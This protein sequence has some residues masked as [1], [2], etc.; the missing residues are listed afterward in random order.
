MARSRIR[1]EEQGIIVISD[2]ENPC[3]I[4]CERLSKLYG[5]F[6]DN[7]CDIYDDCCT[8]YYKDCNK[9][10]YLVEKP[11]QLGP[12]NLKLVNKTSIIIK[13]KGSCC[14]PTEPKDCYCDSRCKD[15]DDCCSDYNIDCKKLAASKSKSSPSNTTKAQNITSKTHKSQNKTSENKNRD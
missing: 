10:E 1:Q 11:N 2:D 4:E 7:S 14:G 8:I 13:Q 5:C 9:F 15:F 3:L 12:S 6:C